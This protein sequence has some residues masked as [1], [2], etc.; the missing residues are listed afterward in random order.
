LRVRRD[1]G[2]SSTVGFAYTDR[3]DGSAWNRVAGADVRLVWRKIWVS[4]AQIAA[5]WTNDGAGVQRGLA[6]ATTLY[7]RTGR[8]YGNHLEIAGVHPDFRA[9]AGFVNRTDVVDARIFNR[10]SFYGRPGAFVEQ[11]STF[12]GIQPVWRYDDLFPDADPARGPAAA[13]LSTIEG[14]ISDSWTFALRGGWEAGANVQVSH[15]RFLDEDYAG[16]QVDSVGTAVPPAVPGGCMASGR[17]RQPQHP[18]PRPHVQCVHRCRELPT[19]AE[20]SAGQGGDG[21][22]TATWKDRRAAHRG[23]LGHRRRPAPRTA[24][25]S[26]RQHPPPQTVSA[27]AGHLRATSVGAGRRSATPCAIR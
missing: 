24:A 11:A 4:D 23:P 7:D 1:L 20:A 10:F 6:W 5:S 3:I 13:S 2:T 15:Q 8:S 18:E 25:G 26:R 12:I 14:S 27:D 21:L 19:F 16:Y 17:Q 22:L 9:D